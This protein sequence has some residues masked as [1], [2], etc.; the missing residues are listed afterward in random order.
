MRQD[1]LYWLAYTA[2]RTD[3][4]YRLISCPYYAKRTVKGDRTFF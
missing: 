1:L 2:L 4:E 3:Y